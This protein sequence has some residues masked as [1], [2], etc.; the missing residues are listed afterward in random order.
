MKIKGMLLIFLIYLSTFL[1]SSPNALGK[2]LSIEIVKKDAFLVIAPDRGYRGNQE[3][4]A[5]FHEFSQQYPARLV[6]V[7]LSEEY[8]MPIEEELNRAIRQLKEEGASRLVLLPLVLS[9][10][11]PHLKKTL[12]LLNRDRNFAALSRE[13][14][15]VAPAMSEDYRIAQILE[16]RAKML[17]QNP[18]EERLIVIGYGATTPDEEADMRSGL[19]SLIHEVRAYLP[20]RETEVIILYHP[21]AEEEV[22]K[23]ADQRAKAAL[24]ELASEKG[25]R[26][27]VIPFHLGFKHTDSMQLNRGIRSMLNDPAF[28]YNGAELFPHPNLLRWLRQTANRFRPP[29]A[30]E[31][32]VVVMPHGAGHYYNRKILDA[33]SPLK[34]KYLLEVAFGMA[35][36]DTLQEAV[37]KL[38]SR[39]V[40]LIHVV[41]LYD[42]SASLKEATEYVLGL[43]KAPAGHG[44]GGGAPQR[45]RS[46]AL[47][48]TSGG[49]D[50]HPLISEVL[51]ERVLEV[52][53]EPE[54]ETVILLA[55]GARSDETDLLWKKK[56]EIKARFIKEKSGKPFKEIRVATLREDWPE[57]REKAVQEIR[58]M[59]EEAG[60]DGGRAIVIS[61]RITGAGP[62][63]KYLK[64][65]DYLFNGT[66]IAPHPN[67]TRWIEQEI[68]NGIKDL[69]KG[70]GRL[71]GA[72]AR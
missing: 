20:F 47:F 54:R 29:T 37:E 34:K 4:E 71:Q 5:I 70:E 66:G 67:L 69:L 15:V 64:G 46:S 31:I 42:T 22:W 52:S 17:S 59:I 32:G 38:E 28:H 10:E 57:K 44:H 16:D 63:R 48:S 62:Y 18:V 1:I 30:E 27:I 43:R 53:R 8:D 13:Q 14:W 9:K 12:R 68:E 19:A 2:D 3:I 51:L 41:R 21:A 65:L 55:H 35:D 24:Q 58:K 33:I 23:N 61:N 49:L 11:D 72:D 56:M 39:G 50:D 45:V 7:S 6:F 60:K 25:L 40:K 26:N 36:T